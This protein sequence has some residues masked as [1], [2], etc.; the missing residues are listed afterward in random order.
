[1]SRWVLEGAGPI[2]AVVTFFLPPLG[3]W[4][5]KGMLWLATL[6]RSGGATE[7]A[8]RDLPWR[9]LGRRCVMG[10]DGQ[11]VSCVWQRSVTWRWMDAQLVT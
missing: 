2:C 9:A 4:P 1:M 5:P 11:D 3:A 8:P 7:D 10:T 6:V